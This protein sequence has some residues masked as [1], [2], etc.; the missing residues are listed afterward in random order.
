MS[1]EPT[2]VFD[3]K[4]GSSVDPSPKLPPPRW[5]AR[6][7][8]GCLGNLALVGVGLFGLIAA[9]CCISGGLIDSVVREVIAEQQDAAERADD[10]IFSPRV[11]PED[12]GVPSG[13]GFR[14]VEHGLRQNAPVVGEPPVPAEDQGPAYS[15][16]PGQGP[17]TAPKKGGNNEG[18]LFG[19]E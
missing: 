2:Y 11:T 10:P 19:V 15:F 16:R 13:S 5:Q 8:R 9:W 7:P 3:D 18:D 4:S 17:S 6:R 12:L 1:E 14:P